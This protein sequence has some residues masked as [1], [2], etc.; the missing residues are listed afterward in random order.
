MTKT[1]D[2]IN[3]GAVTATLQEYLHDGLKAQFET[4][5]YVRLDLSEGESGYD[6]HGKTSSALKYVGH[7]SFRGYGTEPDEVT[8]NREQGLLL[9]NPADVQTAINEN[10]ALKGVVVEDVSFDVLSKCQPFPNDCNGEIIED[11]H[12]T[13]VLASVL[14]CITVLIMVGAAVILRRHLNTRARLEAAEEAAAKAVENTSQPSGDDDDDSNNDIHPG[15]ASLLGSAVISLGIDK[16]ALP[17]EMPLTPDTTTAYS[18]ERPQE[19]S[20]RPFGDDDDEL[21]LEYLTM[22]EDLETTVGEEQSLSP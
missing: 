22:D 3:V 19:I 12:V 9:M 18:S 4:L 10:D 7:C 16:T 20:I 6:S 17:V 1:G 13:L 11:D 8:F 15:C 21:D 14:G 5:E 2:Q